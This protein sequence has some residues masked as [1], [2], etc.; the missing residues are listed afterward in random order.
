MPAR[1]NA[2]MHL[3]MTLL[4]LFFAKHTPIVSKQTA[5]TGPHAPNPHTDRTHPQQ[6]KGHA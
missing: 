2:C 4:L 1:I 5:Q 6:A 3:S